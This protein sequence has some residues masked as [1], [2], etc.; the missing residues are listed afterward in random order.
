M[1]Q[2]RVKLLKQ[3]AMM[4]FFDDQSFLCAVDSSGYVFAHF[5]PDMIGMYQGGQHLET[6]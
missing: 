2:A 6:D 5:N 1:T 3:L 4:R